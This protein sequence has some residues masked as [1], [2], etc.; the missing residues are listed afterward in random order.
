M[1]RFDV[2][3]EAIDRHAFAGAQAVA[4]LVVGND[5]DAALEEVS[6]EIAVQSHVVVVAVA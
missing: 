2:F 3:V 4:E 5:A 1:G 6:D